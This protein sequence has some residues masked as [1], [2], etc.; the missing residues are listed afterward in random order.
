MFQVTTLLLLTWGALAF[1]AEYAWAYAPLLVFCLVPA[2]LALRMN[3]G[4]LPSRV[5]VVGLAVVVAAGVIQALAPARLIPTALQSPPPIDFGRLYSLI[6]MQSAP[7]APS[8]TISI[9]PD[10]TWL[11]LAFITAFSLL[12]IGA[13]RG[14]SAVGAQKLIGGIIALGVVVA[15]VGLIQ[16]AVR[17]EAIYGFWRPPKPGVPFAPFMNENHF[18]GWMVMCLSLAFGAFAGEVAGSLRDV[19]PGWRDRLL[20]IASPAAS[21]LLLIAFA[22]A[23]MTLSLIV[24]T[25]RGGLVGLSAVV[26]IGLFWLLRRQ[27]GWRRVLASLAFVLVVLLA[28][29]RGD[30][31]RT[32]GQ[33]EG[34]SADLGGRKELWSDALRVIQAYPIT[35]T[36]LNTYGIAMLHYQQDYQAGGAVVEAHNDYLQLA[37]EGGL[38]VGLPILVVLGTFF[39]E[40]WRRFSSGRDNEQTFWLRAGAVTGLCAIAVMESFDF[41]LQMPGAAALFVVLAAIAVHEPDAAPTRDARVSRRTAAQ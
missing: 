30:V 8:A 33:F 39:R 21:R 7:E 28:M 16:A 11:G 12:F 38:L 41:T 17:A 6:T 35:G 25:S 4:V 37:A 23:V 24:A 1:G 19:R 26:A 5:L 18:A 36:G 31:G 22:I 29:T 2:V 27:T 14:I 13:A 40:V 9:A 32:L 10:R 34:A 20:W 3:R 15:F